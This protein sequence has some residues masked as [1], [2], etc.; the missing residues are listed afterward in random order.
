MPAQPAKSRMPIEG[1][2][3]ERSTVG[4]AAVPS[5][6]A[7]EV[8]PRRFHPWGGQKVTSLSSALRL[9]ADGSSLALGGF[10]LYR[11][12]MAAVLALI[13]R[14]L[15]NVTLIDYIAAFEADVMIGAGCVSSIRT[16]YC[17]MEIFGLAPMYRAAVGR[18]SVSVVTET[19][20]TLA[21]GLRA[22]RARTDF[23]PARI[24]G[25]TQMLEL[26]PDLKLVA[27]PYSGVEF[28]A[29]PAVHPDVTIVHALM[30]D[31][32][33]N[34]VLGGELALDVDLAAASR[35]T[36]VTTD[37]IVPR[38]EIERRGADLLG[39]FVDAVVECPRGA[40]P[41]SCHPEYLPD[42][43]LFADYMQACE[44]GRFAEFC[45]LLEG[46]RPA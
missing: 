24:F 10:T 7:R 46:R 6:A 1:P 21:Y 15:R 34:A 13:S 38:E 40:W 30:A 44:E 42:F 18:G 43:A 20:A 27:S 5:H 22:A 16:C 45:A 35:H 39:G 29:V 25:G 4:A 8:P 31:E 33:G 23:V 14:G 12:P 11:R 32:T 19:E 37:R 41:T 9:V 2:E 28:V 17:G 3:G 26:R 36:I